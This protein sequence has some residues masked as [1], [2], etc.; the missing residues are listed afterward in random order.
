[1]TESD[2]GDGEGGPEYDVD[3]RE[4][5]GE[6]EIGRGEEGVFKH[7]LLRSPPARWQNLHQNGPRSLRSLAAIHE[8]YEAY[9]VADDF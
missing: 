8:R 7:L 4:H 2:G 5:P 3:F 6:Y 1:V 9:R